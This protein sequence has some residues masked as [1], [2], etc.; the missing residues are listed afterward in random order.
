MN[1]QRLAAG[2]AVAVVVAAIVTGLVISGSPQRQRLLR[3]DEQRIQDLRSL[4]SAVHRHYSNGSTLPAA[5]EELVD[6]RNLSALPRD[7]VS[8]QD[9]GYELLERRVFQVC[10]EFALPS[11]ESEPE[12]FWKHADGRHCF[13]FDVSNLRLE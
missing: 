12:D 1:W 5:L 8:G 11:D 10:A 3:L 4:Q 9:Y 13:R 6:G 2:L 7:P